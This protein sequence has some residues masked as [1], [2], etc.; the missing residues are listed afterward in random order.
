MQSFSETEVLSVDVSR[1]NQVTLSMGQNEGE[2]LSLPVLQFTRNAQA[3]LG[4]IAAERAMEAVPDI[5]GPFY[6]V[7]RAQAIGCIKDM[8]ADRCG[9]LSENPAAWLAQL[10]DG[11]H[12]TIDSDFRNIIT[13]LENHRN[14]I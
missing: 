5:A 14:R 6:E 13:T 3:V 10:R 11:I 8:E 12:R 2:G 4:A 9:L 7:Y 1:D